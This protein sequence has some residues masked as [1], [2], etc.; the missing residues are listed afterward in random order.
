LQTSLWWISTPSATCQTDAV[1]V[2][3]RAGVLLVDP[4]VRGDEMADSGE[5]EIIKKPAP[6]G[7]PIPKLAQSPVAG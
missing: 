1:V 7:V 3:S 6:G 2:Q 4:G 5:G